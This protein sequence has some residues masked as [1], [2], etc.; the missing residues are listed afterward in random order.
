M[1]AKVFVTRRIPE[2]GLLMLKSKVE[3]TINPK[4]EVLTRSELLENIKDK[5]G[6]LSLLTDKMDAE[7]MDNAPSLKIIANY[8]VGYDNID[9]PLATKRGIVVTNTPDVLTETVADF[10][11]S[12]LL[13]IARKIP[14]S[15]NFTRNGKFIGWDP[16]LFLGH[17]IYGK[18]LGIAGFGRIGQAVARRASGFNMRVLYYDQFTPSSAIN[19]KS[20]TKVTFE[21]LLKESD[22][23]SLHVPLTKETHHLIGAKEL[24]IMKPNAYLINTARGPVIDENALVEALKTNKIAG[25]ALDVFEYEPK[26]TEGLASLHNCILAPHIASASLE[27]RTKMSIMAAGNLLA[28]LEGKAPL[29]P[30]N[31]DALKVSR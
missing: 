12:L 15:D 20:Y 23:I 13:S 1:K 2:A 18:T 29:N 22:F 9:I 21:E 11:W 24:E 25:A 7:V 14:E 5:D 4:N 6:I 27:T 8:A 16:L 17:D 19:E 30:V 26:L 31:P 10:T 28:V 3:L